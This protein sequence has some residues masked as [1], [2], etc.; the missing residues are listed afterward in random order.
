MV[1]TCGE[2]AFEAVAR[3]LSRRCLS[4]RHPCVCR[5]CT[6][7]KLQTPS[8]RSIPGSRGFGARSREQRGLHW[9]APYLPNLYTPT[10]R[11]AERGRRLFSGLRPPAAQARDVHGGADPSHRVRIRGCAQRVLLCG[12]RR[13]LQS[14]G[15][16]GRHRVPT[17]GPTLSGAREAAVS[18][19]SHR[20][21]HG[22]RCSR[23]PDLGA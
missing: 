3:A 13:I 5:Q 17:A 19:C 14:S 16:A 10:H 8:W 6:G 7:A 12:E 23:P 20:P 4:A 11:R 1:I 18:A 22:S 2:L 15:R 9:H 21:R